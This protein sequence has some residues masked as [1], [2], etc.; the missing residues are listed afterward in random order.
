MR[1]ALAAVMTLVLV[2][3]L[4]GAKPKFLSTW[5]APGA[6]NVSYAGKKL[7]AFIVSNDM[8]LRQSAEEALAREITAKGAQGIA[9]YRLIPEPET[10]NPAR[11]KEFVERAGV[12]GVVILRL[13]DLEKEK[14][15]AQV[16]Y[17][18]A[19]WY[20]TLWAGYY[21][22]MWGATFDIT[23]ARTDVRLVV[24]MVI[25][26][27]ATNKLL[28]GGTSETTNPKDAQAYIKGLTDGAVEQMQ[29]DGLIA[30]KR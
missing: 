28:W 24:E 5:K 10:R 12:S 8:A 21:P 18:S 23:P 14:Q 26:D 15:P 22:Y 29:K 30:K 11:A 19:A 3:P 2:A 6:T 17:Q 13:V 27:V 7:A 20:D 16:I 1:H 4:A 9:A 25:F